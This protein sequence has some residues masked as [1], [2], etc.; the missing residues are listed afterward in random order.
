MPRGHYVRTEAH[1][2]A[3]AERVRK[4]D[5]SGDKNSRWSGDSV[6]YSGVHIWMQK[7]FGR[8]Q[9]CDTC[10]STTAKTFDW[11]NIS[12]Q[13]LRDR[14]DWKRLCRSCHMKEDGR[15]AAGVQHMLAGKKAGRSHV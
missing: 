1:R 15:A 4:A 11:A 9:L 14:A 12:G 6:G 8:P 3:F 5:R 7:N 10:G 13:Y 2:R